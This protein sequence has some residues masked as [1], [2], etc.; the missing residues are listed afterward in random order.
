MD[1]GYFTLVG[2]RVTYEAAAMGFLY[3]QVFCG[4]TGQL[5][6]AY[7]GTLNTTTLISVFGLLCLHLGNGL[8]KVYVA[9]MAYQM[10]LDLIWLSMWASPIAGDDDGTDDQEALRWMN[11]NKLVLG[12]EVI[13]FILRVLA[14]PLWV[15]M[16]SAGNLDGSGTGGYS[17]ID[18]RTAQTPAGG[19]YQDDS[20]PR[21]IPST[22]PTWTR[23]R[24]SS[25]DTGSQPG[26]P[27]L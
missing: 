1:Q 9:L 6:W 8:A 5:G 11:A 17:N 2:W 15:M 22:P 23:S 20:V 18:R 10:F 14:T 13:A 3:A 19:P 16:W 27:Y 26:Q 25:M 7:Q 12:M 21:S 24:A 4:M